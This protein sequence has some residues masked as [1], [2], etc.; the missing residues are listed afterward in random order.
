MYSPCAARMPV[1][2]RRAVAPRRLVDDAGAN[3]R[4]LELRAVFRAVVAHDH[5]AGDAGALQVLRAVFDTVSDA[6]RLVQA[7]KDDA[8]LARGTIEPRLVDV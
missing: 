5:L 7:G 3:A 4:R 8:D 2:K 1:R 6:G